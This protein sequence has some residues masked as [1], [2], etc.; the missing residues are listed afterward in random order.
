[1]DYKLPDGTRTD[2]HLLYLE[3]WSK[4]AQKLDSLFKPLGYRCNAYD[5][6]FSM[7]SDE[8]VNGMKMYHS[9]TLPAHVAMFLISQV[10]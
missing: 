10:K 7:V 1:M 3:K 9:F 6:D 2:F 5:P 8:R 4:A